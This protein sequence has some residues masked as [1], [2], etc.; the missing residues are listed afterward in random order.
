MMMSERSWKNRW[1]VGTFEIKGFCLDRLTCL[2]VPNLFPIDL[3]TQDAVDEVAKG[4]DVGLNLPENSGVLF[5][6]NPG[7]S[8]P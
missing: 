1:G 7:G 4:L 6:T 5:S 8:M 3:F 2:G